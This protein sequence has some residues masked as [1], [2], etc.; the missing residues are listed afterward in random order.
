MSDVRGAVTNVTPQTAVSSSAS[1]FEPEQLLVFESSFPNGIDCKPIHVQQWAG[2]APAAAGTCIL[3]HGTGEGA[4]VWDVFAPELARLFNRVIAVDLR[5]HGDSAWRED[6][7]Y[8]LDAYLQDTMCVLR[9]LGL[10][11]MTLVGHSIGAAIALRIAATDRVRV[12]RLILVDYGPQMSRAAREHAQASFLAQFRSYESPSDYA[13]QLRSQQPLASS[14]V[15]RHLAERAL[16]QH[17]DGSYVLKSDPAVA[18]WLDP[19]LDDEEELHRCVRRVPCRILLIRGMGSAMLSREG[20][21]KICQW[22]RLAQV[23]TIDR[24]GHAVMSDNPGAF[25]MAVRKFCSVAVA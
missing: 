5:G 4:Y 12:Q 21:A 6:K 10:R 24:A 8:Q 23:M 2:L 13:T 3:I 7:M 25:L 20:A 15:I 14:T 16:R 1:A 9:L 19:Q 22:H 11:S 18:K 17:S